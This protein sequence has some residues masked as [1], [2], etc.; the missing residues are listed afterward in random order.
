MIFPVCFPLFSFSNLSISQVEAEERSLSG[1]SGHFSGMY[2]EPLYTREARDGVR[3]HKRLM[4]LVPPS[5][6][7]LLA[8]ATGK[9]DALKA[10]KMMQLPAAAHNGNHSDANS[11][12]VGGESSG[13]VDLP[14]ANKIP[15]TYSTNS[16][17][18]VGS[19]HSS[20]GLSKAGTIS[21]PPI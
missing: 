15:S 10:A 2:V 20:G 21:L 13:T 3:M 19:S 8:T 18:L 12:L 17:Q 4:E 16:S 9:L 14:P 6:E 1:A 5:E 11:A 7:D